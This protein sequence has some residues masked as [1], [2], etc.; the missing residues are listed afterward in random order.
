MGDLRKDLAIA[1]AYNQLYTSVR[2]EIKLDDWFKRWV[3]VYKK[4]SVRPNTL[5]EYTHIYNKNISPIL[6]N[7]NINSLVKTDI[8][9]LIKKVND[10]AYM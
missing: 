10:D 1:I 7:R 2:D 6:G 8:Q 9:K 3:D 4:K 5:R